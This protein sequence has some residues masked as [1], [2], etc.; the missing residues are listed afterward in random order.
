MAEAAP[1][2]DLLTPAEFRSALETL[3]Q[4]DQ[5]S[6]HRQASARAQG[7]GM[8]PNDLFQEAVTRSLEENG[9]R[10]CPRDVKVATFLD[11]VMRSIASHAREKQKRE[12][13]SSASKG[14]EHDPIVTTSDPTPSP[15][16]I[17]TGR[18]DTLK[19]VAQIV[20]MFDDDP[21]AQAIVIG[22]MEGWSP[23]M[24]CEVEPMSDK[25]YAAANKRMRRTLR[26]ECSKGSIYEQKGK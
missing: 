24:I 11:N 14:D 18:L 22:K 4:I 19:M 2:R 17:V 15:E 21:K 1:Q 23:H 13:P 12:T 20:A 25:E 6:L 26:R 9:G 10:N 3:S 8:E 5:I 16:E 7:T